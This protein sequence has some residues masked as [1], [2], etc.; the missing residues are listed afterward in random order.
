MTVVILHEVA[1]FLGERRRSDVLQLLSSPSLEW[2][3]SDRLGR[4]TFGRMWQL[5][6]SAMHKRPEMIQLSTLMASVVY[7]EMRRYMPALL[8]DSANLIPQVFPVRME[9]NAEEPPAQWAHK[10]EAR[11]RHPLATSLYYAEVE[12]VTGGALALH[13]SSGE[14][15]TRVHPVADQ[16]VAI[17]GDQVHSV[18][19][20]TTG[21]RITVVTN[22]Y[23]T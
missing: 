16:L 20:L 17:A 6:N 2:E 8:P 18:E 4:T 12:N 19:P 15:C 1:E 21:K 10:D 22:F 7:D 3:R 23:H 13:D 9:G 5:A 14:V 11:G